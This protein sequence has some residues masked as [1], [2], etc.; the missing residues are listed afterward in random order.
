LHRELQMTSLR[1]WKASRQLAWKP[2]YVVFNYIGYIMR[3]HYSICTH[4]TS[5][6]I[7]T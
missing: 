2:R 5:S 3:V 6:D 4:P 1:N 7:P